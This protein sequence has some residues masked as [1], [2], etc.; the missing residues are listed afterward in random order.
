MVVFK[1][2]KITNKQEQT[3]KVEKQRRLVVG[4]SLNRNVTKKKDTNE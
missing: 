2:I 3:H 4:F 1:R